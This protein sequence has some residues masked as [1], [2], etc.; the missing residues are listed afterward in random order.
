MT[1]CAHLRDL[2][3]LLAAAC[4]RG[5]VTVAVACGEDPAAIEA[6]LAAEQ[7]GLARGVL[8]GDPERIRAALGSA[9]E[10][11]GVD[12][13]QPESFRIEPASSAE[14]AAER[15]VELVRDGQAEILLKG[16]IPSGPILH[17]VLSH[18]HGLRRGRL[19]SDCFLF[20]HYRRLIC[21]TDGGMNVAPD[22]EAKRQILL[23]AVELF[24]ALGYDRPRVAVMS[25]VEAV[26]PDHAPSQDAVALSAMAWSDC[27]V[28]GP[29]SL[30]LAVSPAAAIKKHMESA[31]AGRADILLCP[32][33]VSANMLAKA[34]TQFARARLA[35][36]VMG[37]TAPVLIPSR[38]DN[39]EAKLF[40]IALGS[41]VRNASRD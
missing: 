27:I 15:A 3:D 17:A 36:V 19:L 14:Q 10:V 29:L 21:V 22:L 34:T 11:A 16:A 5:P 31:V 30:D 1:T 35:H 8:V 25:A 40:S 32:D 9:R 23:N 33:L 2:D 7:A 39:A 24:H 41:M 13:G 6:L 38:S 12:R 20:E 26:L 28:E 4:A 37:A 18:E